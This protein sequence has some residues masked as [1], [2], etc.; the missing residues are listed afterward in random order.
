MK[1]FGRRRT[2]YPLDLTI[3][4]LFE[5]G[6]NIATTIHDYASDESNYGL[7]L[8][9][10]IGSRRW[11]VGSTLLLGEPGAGKS[12]AAYEMARAFTGLGIL[13]VV[14]RASEFKALLSP[15]HEYAE[16]MGQALKDAVL[17]A[18]L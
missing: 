18:L 17:G 9:D 10:A 13:P 6:V 3:E 1:D 16:V 11:G 8:T 5:R 4:E 7:D 14:L 12:V 15:G 2:A